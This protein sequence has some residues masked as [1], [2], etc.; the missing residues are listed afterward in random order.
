MC[1][2]LFLLY[3]AKSFFSPKLSSLLFPHQQNLKM[4]CKVYKIVH[5]HVSILPHLKT[6]DLKTSLSISVVAFPV[7]QVRYQQEIAI[8]LEELALL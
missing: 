8:A 6:A 2:D 3:K 7:H 5:V 1:D 4:Y